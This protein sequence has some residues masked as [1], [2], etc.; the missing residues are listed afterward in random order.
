MSNNHQNIML[1]LI[2]TF[3][4]FTTI[5]HSKMR[6]FDNHVT[7]QQITCAPTMETNVTIS[8]ITGKHTK[9]VYRHQ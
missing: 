4:I 2:V 8:K 5:N 6:F 3:N 1:E 7:N 9:L